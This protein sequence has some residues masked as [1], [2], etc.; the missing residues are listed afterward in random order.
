[1]PPR[2]PRETPSIL[3]Q[4]LRHRM[5]ALPVISF[6]KPLSMSQS[7][8]IGLVGLS[9]LSWTY[10]AICIAL[11]VVQTE[12]WRSKSGRLMETRGVSLSLVDYT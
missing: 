9:G 2:T 8:F 4:V 10:P 1:V 6:K 12:E 7:F 5:L 11:L 3:D